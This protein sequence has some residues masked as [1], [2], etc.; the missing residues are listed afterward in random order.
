MSKKI[1]GGLGNILRKSSVCIAARGK[2][3]F[4]WA[5][6]TLAQGKIAARFRRG[7]ALVNWLNNLRG[8]SAFSCRP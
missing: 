5:Y 3:T 2:L 1:A 8:K 7:C 6:L 4:V